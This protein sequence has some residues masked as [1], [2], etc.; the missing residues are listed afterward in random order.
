MKQRP[1]CLALVSREYPPFYGG[2]IGTYA[3]WIVPALANAGVR[4]HVVTEVHD[5]THPRVEVSGNVTTHRVPLAIGRGGWTSGAARFSINAG[6]KIDE[7]KR[8]GEI[9]IAEFAE[10]E[11]AAAALLLLQS[12][13][14]IGQRVPTLIH[15]HTPSEM[16]FVLRSL[17]SRALDQSLSSYFIAERLAL[18]LADRIGAP[19]RFIADWAHEHYDLSEHPAVIPYA[20][21]PA[22]RAPPPA[23]APTVLYVG[24]IEPRKGV[25]P[26]LLG[27]KRVL[28]Q[29]PGAQLRLAGADTAGA[30]DGGSLRAY[31]LELLTPDERRSVR[32]LGR[33]NSDALHEEYANA[34]ICV[35]PSLWENFP[36]T[37]I[38]SMTH[39]RAVAVSDHGG[40]IEMIE[41][42]DAGLAFAAGDPQDLANCL[43]SMLNEGLPRLAQRG[44]AARQR[45][46]NLCDP[47]RVA[48]QR[49]ELYC[50]TIARSAANKNDANSSQFQTMFTEWKRAES[51][52]AGNLDDIDLPTPGPEIARWVERQERELSEMTA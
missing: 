34:A 3:R 19:S 30:P 36:N 7:L 40:M 47:D 38:E 32:F 15:L 5:A 22:H 6:R 26:L 28:A 4:V 21:P 23:R 29:H 10:C 45:I 52:V 13:R 49:I 41:G 35:I 9:S 44:R 12:S 20:L 2:G 8:R 1:L 46:T 37:C 18:R 16:L 39:A 11:A 48:E 31:L 51:V 50:S 14:R 17:S 43:S 27:W 42:T 33:L 24:R 25:E